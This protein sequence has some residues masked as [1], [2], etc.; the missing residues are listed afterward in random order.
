MLRGKNIGISTEDLWKILDGLHDEIM[1]YDND[2]RL[3]YVNNACE[4]HYG[5]SQKDL[6]GASFKDL[7]ETYWGNSTLPDVYRTKQMVAKHQITNLGLDIVT[8]SVPILDDNNNI[9]YV[10]QNVNDIYNY[11]DISRAEEAF[12]NISRKVEKNEE[13]I[14]A[15]ESMRQTIRLAERL[16]NVLSP[17]LITGET[18]TG[19]S[20]LAKYVHSISNRASQP[21]VAV[22]CA[23][24]NPNL[25]ESELFGYKKGAFSGASASGKKGIV[26]I[27]DKGTLFLDEISEIPMDLQGKLLEFIQEKEFMPLGSEKKSRVDVRIIAATNKDLRQ[28]VENHAFREDLYYRLNAFEV[29]LPPLRERPEDV[30]ALIDHFLSMFNRTY[31]RSMTL[32]DKAREILLQYRWPGNIRELAHIM[33]KIVVLTDGD[34]IMPADIPNAI[35]EIKG[36]QAGV[37]RG[38]DETETATD[39]GII[40]TVTGAGEGK[41]GEEPAAAEMTGEN[42][43]TGIE[44]AEDA[45]M[46]DTDTVKKTLRE[47]L[48]E[49]E[50]RM[51]REAYARCGNSV[52][53][54]AEL[55]VSQPTAYR[56]IR[57]YVT[58]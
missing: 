22:N 3:V 50:C 40:G 29:Q 49:T 31:L 15:S 12:V 25:I 14:Y 33:E 1:I 19:K 30:R 35:Y 45:G 56:L 9:K 8:I 21:F 48:E 55:G 2:Y 42:D 27:A 44:A 5:K 6:I 54:A 24:I 23:C 4:R 53:T 32:S 46:T 10:A 58:K 20:Q 18:G 17:F 37:P 36:R 13:Y 52:K 38:W 34:V 43:L 57:K 28:M 39:E 11:L 16:K 41:T 26:Q 51:V 47:A 7:D